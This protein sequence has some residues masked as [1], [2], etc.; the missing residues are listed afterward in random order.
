MQFFTCRSQFE[1]FP[2]DH[3]A[4]FCR[5]CGESVHHRVQSFRVGIVAIVDDRTVTQLENLSAF[6]GL[7]ERS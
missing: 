2:C 3:N 4:A 1:H 7:L 5:H 6:V